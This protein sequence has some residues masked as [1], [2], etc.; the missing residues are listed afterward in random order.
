M[1]HQGKIEQKNL[2]EMKQII[3][4]NKSDWIEALQ[5]FDDPNVDF[6]DIW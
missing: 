2:D 5:Q 4:L 6:E 3:K 1:L